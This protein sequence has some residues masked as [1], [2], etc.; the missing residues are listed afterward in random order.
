MK[1]TFIFI[2]LISFVLTNCKSQT[3]YF[4]PKGIIDKTEVLKNKSEWTELNNME[5]VDKYTRIGDSLFGGEIACNVKPLSG[6]DTKSFKVLAGTK[7]AKDKNHVFYPIEIKCIDYQDCGV[8]YYGKIIVE[9]AN[10]KTFK[11]LGKDYAS[12][13]I[14]AFFR[15]IQ[16]KD[17]DGKSFKVINGP[18]Y[19]YFSVDKNN[20]Y[21]HSDIF[22][23]AD[24]KTFY[25][26]KDDK[27]NIGDVFIIGDKNR[28]WEFIPPS[29]IKEIEKK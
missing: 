16:I 18:D 9:S 15:G 13:G 21:I 28:E 8:C 2:I 12:D 3:E 22:K 25:Y 5:S 11:Y 4:A 7:Y 24:A 29:S 14:N 20:V 10:P 17:A 26:N 27:R 1:K 23:S 19:F 6:I